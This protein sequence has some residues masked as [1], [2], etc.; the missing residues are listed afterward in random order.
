MHFYAGHICAQAH[1]GHGIMCK[2][3][4]SGQASNL[5]PKAHNWELT[6]VGMTFCLMAS[7]FVRSAACPRLIASTR[8]GRLGGA[9]LPLNLSCH[10]GQK[11]RRSSTYAQ[12]LCLL[13]EDGRSTCRSS[14]KM[15]QSLMDAALCVSSARRGMLARCLLE[16]MLTLAVLAE[17]PGL[18]L[19]TPCHLQGQFGSC[20]SIWLW[21]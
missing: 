19:R 7:R 17:S 4:T 9:R 8:S 20:L 15:P 2:H 21:L 14:S 1:G 5:K 16:Q 3:S 18:A 13:S 12:W 11:R 10:V 6:G